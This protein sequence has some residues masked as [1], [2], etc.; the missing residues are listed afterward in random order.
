MDI[1]DLQKLNVE[2]AKFSQEF[3][4]EFINLAQ[5]YLRRDKRSAI[6]NMVH[7]PLNLIMNIIAMDDK[8][9][10]PKIFPE[11][12]DMFIRFMRPF[13]KLKVLWGQIPNAEWASEYK[14]LHS[15]QFDEWFPSEEEKRNFTQWFEGKRN[16]QT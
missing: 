8:N 13:I 14:R 1:K 10:M 9:V 11:L 15:A 7:L 3:N 5:K 16:D 2:F 12:P 6:V 4:D